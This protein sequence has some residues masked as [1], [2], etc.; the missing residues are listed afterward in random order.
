MG[1]GNAEERN[2]NTHL[3]VTNLPYMDLES[4]YEL[5]SNNEFQSFITMD[6]FCAGRKLGNKSFD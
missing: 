3:L 2:P 5:Y 1:W 4:C 6:K